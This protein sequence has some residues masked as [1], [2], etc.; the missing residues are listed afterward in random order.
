MIAAFLSLSKQKK[1]M[2]VAE[3]RNSCATVLGELALA[4][5]VHSVTTQGRKPAVFV[6]E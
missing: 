4:G 3:N 5:S 2:I 6:S 1:Q